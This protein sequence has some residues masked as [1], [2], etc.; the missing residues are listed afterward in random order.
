MVPDKGRPA[1]DWADLRRLPARR[2]DEEGRRLGA[3]AP[4]TTEPSVLKE[5]QPGRRPHG[6]SRADWVT[7]AAGGDF[8]L[9]VMDD[10]SLWATGL[11][12]YGN[13]GLGTQPTEAMLRVHGLP[14]PRADCAACPSSSWPAPAPEV[15]RYRTGA[16]F[17]AAAAHITARPPLRRGDRRAGQ[18]AAG[19]PSPCPRSPGAHPR[20]QR[21]QPVLRRGTR[22]AA[23]GPRP[24][25]HPRGQSRPQ[26]GRR[27]PSAGLDRRADRRA[28]RAPQSGAQ[29]AARRRR[30]RRAQLLGRGGRSRGTS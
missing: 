1:D 9:A 6:G 13:L 25:R 5:H 28:P 26:A 29:S 7:A 15:G 8:S 4:T 14:G 30:R 21:R 22:Q 3:G 18:D 2:G 27:G 20:A 17:V 23:P 11:N 12:M 19:G 10:G 16:G 24:S